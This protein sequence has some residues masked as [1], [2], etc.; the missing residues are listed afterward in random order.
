MN[1]LTKFFSRIIGIIFLMS[2]VLKLISPE[3]I[4]SE[5]VS[6]LRI[7]KINVP[8]L[9]PVIMIAGIM[10]ILYECYLGLVYLIG[11][12]SGIHT[13]LSG[14]LVLLFII[15]NT[16]EMNFGSSQ[17]CY[18]F[19][20]IIESSRSFTLALDFFMLAVIL[21]MIQSKTENPNYEF[22]TKA[23]PPVF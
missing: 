20:A 5:I 16:L 13:L 19:G 9:G 2:G 8:G 21:F 18:C 7:I 11:R 6:L 22:T 1:N 15:V 10:I 14:C 12:I 17:T 3:T 4:E 23:E